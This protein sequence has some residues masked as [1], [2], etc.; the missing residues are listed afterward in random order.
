MNLQSAIVG[1]YVIYKGKTILVEEDKEL[2]C[3]G[4]VFENE[5]CDNDCLGCFRV[6]SENVIFKAVDI[7]FINF[8]V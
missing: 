6:D 4:C 1:E 7:Q 3:K 8:N 2:T 5:D